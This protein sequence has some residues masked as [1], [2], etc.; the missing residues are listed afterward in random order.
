MKHPFR[1]AASVLATGAVSFV[2]SVLLPYEFSF[3][4][5]DKHHWY[6]YPLY[7]DLGILVPTVAVILAA[8]FAMYGL[9]VAGCGRRDKRSK[10]D[11]RDA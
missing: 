8:F 1:A 7:S 10:R 11:D 4:S 6:G 3:V 5:I 9:F 2:L